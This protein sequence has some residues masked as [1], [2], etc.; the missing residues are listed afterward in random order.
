MMNK[1]EKLELTYISN[2]LWKET[3]DYI[4]K[5]RKKIEKSLKKDIYTKE[6]STFSFNAL[7]L[8]LSELQMNKYPAIA[9]EEEKFV[10]MVIESIGEK[11]P[12]LED[13]KANVEYLENFRSLIWG[14][15]R[16]YEKSLVYLLRS[17]N[18]CNTSLSEIR[19]DTVFY[20][21]LLNKCNTV[22]YCECILRRLEELLKKIINND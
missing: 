10:D 12:P 3:S 2:K 15:I 16:C 7:R 13:V 17:F 9:I 8:V 14:H 22:V 20:Q 6:V 4:Y 1:K 19:G 11:I 5:N 18:K 21:L